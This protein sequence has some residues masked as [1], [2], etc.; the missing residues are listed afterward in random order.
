MVKLKLNNVCITIC[1]A[2]HYLASVCFSFNFLFFWRHWRRVLALT[3][4]NWWTRYWT[5]GCNRTHAHGYFTTSHVWKLKKVR[6]MW[7]KTIFSFA[8]HW[9]DSTIFRC[10]R[11][12]DLWHAS[13]C[14][15]LK[16]STRCVCIIPDEKKERS[17]NFTYLRWSMHFRTVALIWG[18]GIA[19]FGI[20]TWW[21]N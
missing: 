4:C 2:N 18:N 1:D 7:M 20:H 14:H 9:G 17:L 5:S 8:V 3:Q 19:R 10:Q 13:N 6:D 16:W 21:V 15:A 11:N 12:L